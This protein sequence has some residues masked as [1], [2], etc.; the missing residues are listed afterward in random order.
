MPQLIT[1][2]LAFL[3]HGGPPPKKHKTLLPCEV[4]RRTA[5]YV[6]EKFKPA[7]GAKHVHYGN[8]GSRAQSQM[9][10]A[11]YENSRQR[12]AIPV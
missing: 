11:I 5:A 2:C 7:Q 6:Q 12:P 4:H 10:T 3:M 9:A 8:Q 1:L